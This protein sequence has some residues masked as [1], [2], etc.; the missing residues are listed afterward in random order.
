MSRWSG[1]A[2]AAVA[3]AAALVAAATPAARAQEPAL[4]WDNYEKVTLSTSLGEPIDLAVLP[5]RRVL[6]TARDG[7]V[8]L[9]DPAAGTTT[10]INRLN[11]YTVGEMGLQTVTLDPNFATNKWVY[12]YYAPA[13][14]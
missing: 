12:L 10:I 4:N 6:T 14:M 1:R 5:D 13:A 2:A 11:V 8:R 9:V 3:I 7:A